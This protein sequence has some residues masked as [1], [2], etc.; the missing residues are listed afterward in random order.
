MRYILCVIGALLIGCGPSDEDVVQK[1]VEA[2]RGMLPK[3]LMPPDW[4]VDGNGV[5][6]MPREDMFKFGR[7]RMDPQEEEIK[8]MLLELEARLRPKLTWP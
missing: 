6:N 4:T 1:A 2:N 3:G 8:R 7:G 5:W